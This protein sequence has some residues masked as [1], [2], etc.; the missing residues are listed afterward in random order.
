[1][2][3]VREHLTSRVQR[4][5]HLRDLPGET[6]CLSFAKALTSCDQPIEYLAMLPVELVHSPRRDRRLDQRLHAVSLVATSGLLQPH[7]QCLARSDELCQ[8]EAKQRIN[9]ILEFA[10]RLVFL[11]LSVFPLF[12][13]CHH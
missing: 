11:T 1:M 7:G 6:G 5:A 12:T 9:I 8:W 4:S 3:K 13:I 2:C 10:P